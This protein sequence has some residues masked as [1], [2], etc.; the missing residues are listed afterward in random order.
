[1]ITLY[2]PTTTLNFNNILSSESISPKAFYERR[3]F[4]YRRWAT[5][6]EN[7]IE[8]ATLLYDTLPSFSRP[9]NGL[10]DHPL[11]VQVILNENQVKELGNGVFFCDKT[12]YLDPWHTRFIFQSERDKLTALS[13]SDS[14]SETKLL[15][16]YRNLL[17]VSRGESKYDFQQDNDI[18]LNEPEIAQDFSFNRIKGLLYGYYIGANMS[19][20]KDDVK[21]IVEM[22]ELQD[23]L[24][25]IQSSDD[26]NPSYSQRER[27]HQLLGLGVILYD[28]DISNGHMLGRAETSL[29]WLEQ[30]ADNNKILLLPESNEIEILNGQVSSA[31][32]INDGKEKELFKA[33]TNFLFSS[34][35]KKYNG[36]ISTINKELSDELTVIAKRVYGEDWGDSQAKSFL[37][38]LRRHI[39]GE[40]FEEKWDN[41]LLS[42]VA[43]VLT[44]G[45]DWHK[46]LSFMQ[47]KGMCDYRLAFAFYGMLNGFANLTRDFTDSLFEQK[48]LYVAKVYKSFYKQLF[49]RELVTS[50]D[51]SNLSTEKVEVTAKES[52]KD[53]N[54][55]T[56]VNNLIEKVR[57]ICHSLK[58][59]KS[60]KENLNKAI[61]ENGDNESPISFI[62]ILK[63]FSGW[64][65]GDKLN[66]IKNGLYIG[67]SKEDKNKRNSQASNQLD[68]FSNSMHG[69]TQ[70]KAKVTT[71]HDNFEVSDRN[72]AKR[73]SLFIDDYAS[74]F[75]L[76]TTYAPSSIMEKLKVDCDWFVSEYQK[77]DAS[78][79]YAHASHDN[80]KTIPAFKRYIEKKSYSSK[81]NLDGLISKLMEMYV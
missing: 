30:T 1:M 24:S 14:S 4:G 41:N 65:K 11:V 5:I 72:T 43:A 22:R 13:M 21:E 66:A 75:N 17:E 67:E 7:D 58:L 15:R 70:E 19:L 6:E 40:A 44:H 42:S 38:N 36:K 28:I 20:R 12:I 16:L 57:E 63:G 18:M 78:K 47:S 50:V 77:G 25:S 56:K 51:N 39:R 49:S 2:I 79:Y 27:L 45:D 3:G 69:D 10:E 60:Q 23:I 71:A 53:G 80:N 55:L 61:L 59:S 48:P 73:E 62:A 68:L 76:L 31:L 26:H 33:W 64:K 8:N 74:W 81:I 46:L 35:S 37:N 32:T 9:D 52:S 29:S 34:D 54:P